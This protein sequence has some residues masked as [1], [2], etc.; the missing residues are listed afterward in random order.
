MNIKRVCVT[1]NK[2]I[3]HLDKRSMYCDKKC[4]NIDYANQRTERLRIE[5]IEYYKDKPISSY[6]ACKLCGHCAPDLSNH[7]LKIHQITS[8]EY[9]LKFD[10][11]VVKCQD[12]CDKFKVS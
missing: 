1:C 7:I 11:K 9:K 2:D 6:I 8:D 5:S 4:R 12:D 3:S 10:V